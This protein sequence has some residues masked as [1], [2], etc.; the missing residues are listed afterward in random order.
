MMS[1]KQKH[2]MADSQATWLTQTILLAGVS[3][4]IFKAVKDVRPEILRRS[5]LGPEP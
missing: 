4:D 1:E 3:G 5:G 2:L